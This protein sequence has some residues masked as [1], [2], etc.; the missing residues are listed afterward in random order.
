MV[1]SNDRIEAVPEDEKKDV[2]DILEKHGFWASESGGGCMWY[3]K[4]IKYK[5]K[6]AFVA[7][8][9]NG[10][11]GIPESFNEPV[12]VGIYDLDSGE[13]LEECKDFY[14]LRSYLESLDE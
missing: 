10:G 14:S 7:I 2:N 4:S 6:G 8:T 12:M 11:G 1:D 5:G 13:E 3:T 9:D